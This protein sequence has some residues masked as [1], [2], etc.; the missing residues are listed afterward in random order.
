[1]TLLQP[2][3]Q[4]RTLVTTPAGVASCIDTGGPGRAAVFLHGLGTSSYLW[5]HVI[6]QVQGPGRRSVAVDLPL[7]GCTPA[8]Q[9]QDFSLTGLADFVQACCAALK[10]GAVD[11]V[12]NDTGGA[13]AQIL[14]ARH[15]DRVRTLTL[16]NCEAHDNVPPR[17]FLP[18]MWLAR[19]GLLARLAPRLLAD[20]DRA[21]R[22]VYRSGYEDVASLPVEVA[23]AWL[24]PLVGTAEAA[25]HL[26][27]FILSMRADD[28]L[29]AEPGLR[30]LQAPTLIVWGAADPFFHRKWAYWLAS[31]I[32]G[33]TDVLEL[34]EA[35]L[36]FPDERPHELA[37]ALR[38]LWE[39]A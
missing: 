2:F 22:R 16:T 17:R 3:D 12:A 32:P 11:L 4:H 35:K 6:A 1:V 29:A 27:R 19:S 38:E 31:V 20:P 18:T 25:R 39:S 33:V 24:T 5:R 7:H 13:V 37:V 15:P 28:L 10:L 9:D 30:R 14:A 23:R 34:A 26:Q 8:A 21:R 36:F